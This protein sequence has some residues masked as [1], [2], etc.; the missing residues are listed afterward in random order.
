VKFVDLP[1]VAEEGR[2]LDF[3]QQ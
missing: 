2:W 1:A 3:L